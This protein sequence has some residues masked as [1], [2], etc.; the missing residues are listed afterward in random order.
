M[1]SLNSLKN[2]VY[3]N[4]ILIFLGMFEYN[5]VNYFENLYFNF[6]IIMMTFLSRNYFLLNLVN[7]NLKDKENLHDDQIVES[8]PHEFNINLITSTGIE[9]ITYM[10]IKSLIIH[11]TLSYYDILLFI[12]Y[13]FIFELLFD[14]FHYWSHR[15]LHTN[16][17]L[18]VNIH[19]KH[20]KYAHPK[21]IITFYQD[22]LDL[23]ITNSVPQIFTLLL[24]PYI[25]LFLFNI[26]L[27]YK[28]FIEISGHS[29]KKLYPNGSF[30]Q[31]IWLPK[32]L[33]ITLYT[34]DHNLHHSL[35]NCN[36][37]KRFSLWDKVFGTYK[38]I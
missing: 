6:F 2:F 37:S 30:S 21:S 25:S 14:F 29:G 31:F 10:F 27:S 12:P 34:E 22:P 35:S 20:H 16:K 18:Y 33:G 17:F 19:K 38:K 32:M 26:I 4:G 23:L 28:S 5:T 13:S 3:L 7:Y 24:F 11:N 1:I 36:Y 8:Y 9:T 15:I